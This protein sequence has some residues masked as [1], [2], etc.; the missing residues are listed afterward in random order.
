MENL[1]G[2][3]RL[4]SGGKFAE[5][6]DRLA[7]EV[8]FHIYEDRKHLIGKAQ[9]MEFCKGIADY[10]S[11]IETDFREGGSLVAEGKVV[12]YGYGEFKRDGE[13]VNAVHSCDVYEFD[14]MGR[15]RTIHSYCNSGQQ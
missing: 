9:V 1:L 7:D 8:E 13:L 11:S 15:I 4:F 6:A 5:V 10:F 12:I 14:A 3:A 2:V